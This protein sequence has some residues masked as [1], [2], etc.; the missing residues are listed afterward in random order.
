[1]EDAALRAATLFHDSSLRSE[2][3]RLSGQRRIINRKQSAMI[4]DP[5]LLM[6]NFQIVHLLMGGAVAPGTDFE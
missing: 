2:C 3:N 5:S 4:D 6:N 1:M